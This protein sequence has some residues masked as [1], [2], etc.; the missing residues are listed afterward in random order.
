LNGF[1]RSG[2][3]SSRNPDKQKNNEQVGRFSSLC[4]SAASRRLG[5]SMMFVQLLS[6]RK[7]DI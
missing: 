3:D 6:E 4:P 2:F 5:P 7:R 1:K